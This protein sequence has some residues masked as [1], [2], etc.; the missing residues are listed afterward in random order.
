VACIICSAAPKPGRIYCERCRPH[1]MSRKMDKMK[2]RLALQKAWNKAQNAFLCLYSKQPLEEK[3]LSSPYWIEFDHVIPVKSSPFQAIWAVLNQMKRQLTDDEFRLALPMLRDHW[4]GAPFD[5]AAIP[6]KY[7]NQKHKTLAAGPIIDLIRGE[8]PTENC[9][10][11]GDKSHPGSVYCPRCRMFMR[12]R[13][14]NL[15]RRKALQES[16]DRKKKRFIC[17]YTGVELNETDT[18]DPWYISFDRAIPGKKGELVVSAF[19]VTMMKVDLARYEFYPVVNELADCLE[20]GRPFDKGVC[21]FKY[22]NRRKD[23]TRKLKLYPLV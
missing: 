5:K 9:I 15:P 1:I 17:Y 19:W 3:D 11:C 20:A 13:T 2:R 7:W 18:S 22:W 14:E 21:G 8:K 6:F 23:G 4:K 10:V 12:F 16:Y